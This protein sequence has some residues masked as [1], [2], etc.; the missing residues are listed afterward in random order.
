MFISLVIVTSIPENHPVQSEKP[1]NIHSGE[2]FEQHRFSFI[3]GIAPYG[4]MS[5]SQIR[6]SELSLTAPACS[7]IVLRQLVGIGSMDEPAPF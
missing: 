6:R 1:I 3:T 4:P 2:P 5:P 7:S